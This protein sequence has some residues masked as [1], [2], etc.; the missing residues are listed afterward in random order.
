MAEKVI[1]DKKMKLPKAAKPVGSGESGFG[2]GN[3]LGIIFLLIGVLLILSL[4]NFNLPVN[5]G[6]ISTFLQYGAGVGSIL[7]GFSMLIKRKE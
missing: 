5:L 3:I 7:G 1:I 4:M 2:L 6:S